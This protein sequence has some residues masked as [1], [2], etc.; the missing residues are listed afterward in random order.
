MHKRAVVALLAIALSA[1]LAF[2]TQVRPVNLFKMV[3]LA[4]RIFTGQCLKVEE[5]LDSAT[6]LRMTTYTF[7]VNRGLK[8][9]EDGQ[10]LVFRQLQ[11][12]S[13][14]ALSIID[15]PRFNKGHDALLFLHGDS[16]IGL[17]SPVGMAQGY[18][19]V[20]EMPDGQLGVINQFR[21]HNLRHEL[22][23]SKMRSSGLAT[24]E[25]KFL[26]RDGA[27]PLADFVSMVSKIRRSQESQG[28]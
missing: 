6:G 19:R 23:S 1:S 10:T 22:S 7:R 3:Q 15:M 4:D 12:T 9:V 14:S 25:V 11:S 16:A 20:Q 26:S 21:N 13:K 18:F 27:I 17:T 2:A 24:R 28:D 8:G 5:G